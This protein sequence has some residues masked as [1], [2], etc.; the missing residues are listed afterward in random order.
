MGKFCEDSVKWFVEALKHSAS[1]ND[2]IEIANGE[3]QMESVSKLL[4]KSNIASI[5]VSFSVD[6]P[7]YSVLSHPS[8]PKDALKVITVFDGTA[9]EI[10][11]KENRT[12]LKN[13]NAVVLINVPYGLA[14]MKIGSDAGDVSLN[15]CDAK[16]TSIITQSGD[17]IVKNHVS[18]CTVKAKSEHGDVVKN[19]FPNKPSINLLRCKTIDGDIILSNSSE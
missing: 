19:G 18:P 2:Y 11:I 12:K 4:I 3:L 8:V 14:I 13:H 9:Y 15:G 17:I 6:K 7:S 10:S 16:E 1:S 5:K